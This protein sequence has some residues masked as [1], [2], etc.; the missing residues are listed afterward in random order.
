[1][2]RN[3]E[4]LY[5]IIECPRCKE[6]IFV[7]PT[8]GEVILLFCPAGTTTSERRDYTFRMKFMRGWE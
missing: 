2:A 8:R 4:E 3:I 1:M 7:K 6:R 5:G